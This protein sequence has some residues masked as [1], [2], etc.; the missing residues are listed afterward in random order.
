MRRGGLAVQIP[1]PGIGIRRRLASV[2]SFQEHVLATYRDRARHYDITANLYYLLGFRV[3]ASRR[4]AVRALALR[5]G[6]TVVEI[7]CGTGLNFSLVE[8]VIGPEGPA[9]AHGRGRAW[10]RIGMRWQL[11]TVSRR[12]DGA[13]AGCFPRRP[14]RSVLCRAR[15]LRRW[16]TVQILAS[17]P[18]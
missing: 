13:F 1:P 2:G 12:R 8:Q 6:D 5:P 10:D 3:Q 11:G 16:P 9:R 14:R 15:W 4:R 17:V 18:G 7:G